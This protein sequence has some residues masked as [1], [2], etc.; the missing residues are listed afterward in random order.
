MSDVTTAEQAVRTMQEALRKAFGEHEF[1]VDGD[2]E[3]PGSDSV[4]VLWTDGPTEE[5][6]EELA[7]LAGVYVVM[8]VRR[9]SRA[10]LEA[11]LAV[12]E[13][14][15][16]FAY[17]VQ[18]KEDDRGAWYEQVLPDSMIA[19]AIYVAYKVAEGNLRSVEL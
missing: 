10:Y 11:C 18:V 17:G 2:A 9:Y 14:A 5:E 19:R 13:A 15:G 3:G 6:V 8:Q 4:M 7:N 16:A 1:D 12:V